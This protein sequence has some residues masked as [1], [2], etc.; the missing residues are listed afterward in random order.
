M[1]SLRGFLNLLRVMFGLDLKC[2]ES[3][4]QILLAASHH[5]TTQLEEPLLTKQF[6]CVSIDLD[7]ELPC[8]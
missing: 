2:L 4:T 6:F 1:V 8:A 7:F 5:R 3:V